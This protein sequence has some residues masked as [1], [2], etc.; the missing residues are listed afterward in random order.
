MYSISA[1]P[2]S[3]SSF[4]GWMQSTGQTSTHAV[5]FVPTH[6]SQ[7]MYAICLIILG[8]AASAKP[9]VRRAR[10]YNSRISMSFRTMAAL[11][12]GLVGAG[13]A[14]AQVPSEPLA[15]GGGRVTI[16]ADVSASFGGADPGFFNYTDYDHSA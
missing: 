3:A 8:V 10:G 16:G 6:G 7:M 5:S 9:P 2:N 15:F 1:V 12:L 4:R 14:A 11:L 13:R